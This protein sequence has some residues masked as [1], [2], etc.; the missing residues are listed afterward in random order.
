MTL[1]ALI[2]KRDTERLATAIPAIPATQQRESTGT[3]ATIA[4]LAV[5]NPAEAKTPEPDPAWCAVWLATVADHLGITSDAL[6]R[7]GI[8]T[9][10][11]VA[12]YTPA[13]PAAFAKALQHAHPGRFTASDSDDDR[14]H[15]RTCSS[16]TESGRCMAAY[17]GALPAARETR[18]IDTIPRRCV[19]YAPRLDDPDQR[20]GAK[21]WPWM[22]KG[23][24]TLQ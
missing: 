3:V 12:S 13:D 18:P 5:A 19:A 23:S 4:T 24:E 2:R 6:I 7:N 21:R 15:C 16:L 20:P 10:E 11:E 8:I 17:R 1:S 22:L 9:P 14:R